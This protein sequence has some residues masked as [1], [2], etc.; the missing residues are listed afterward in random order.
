MMPSVLIGRQGDTGYSVYGDIL[1][2][3]TEYVPNSF[4][5]QSSNLTSTFTLN[6]FV[7]VKSSARLILGMSVSQVV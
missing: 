5:H 1:M 4:H 2:F 7:F 6:W 3:N